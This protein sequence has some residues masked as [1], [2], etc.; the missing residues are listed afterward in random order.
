MA[1]LDLPNR[2]HG[3]W[4]KR[5]ERRRQWRS[6]PSCRTALLAKHC[7]NV[8]LRSMRSIPTS[9]TAS[10]IVLRWPGKD[11]RRDAHVLGDSLR[12]DRHCFRRLSAE[13]PVVVEL[14]EW[15]RMTDELQQSRNRLANRVREQL[16]RYHPQALAIGDDLPPDW[17]L[18]VALPVPRR[19]EAS[20][21]HA[22]AAGRPQSAVV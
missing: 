17:F 19:G 5:E 16:W 14:R 10:A 20:R 2:A 15:S 12:T 22:T 7:S 11:D 13:D 3:C 21:Q 1:A 6:R 8:V 18:E 9:S 4:R